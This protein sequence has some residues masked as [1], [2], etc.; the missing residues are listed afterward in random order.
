MRGDFFMLI[1]MLRDLRIAVLSTLAV[2]M[3]V[4]GI[5]PVFVWGIAQ[6]VFPENADGSLIREERTIIGSRLVGQGF[7]GK[8]Y[9]HPR[10]SHA[11]SGYDGTGSSG[12]NLGPL[13]R[14]LIE[15]IRR[16]TEVYRREN[17]LP[18]GV[19]IPPDAVTASASGLDPHISVANALLQA[20]RVAKARG[21]HEETL[22]ST[23]MANTMGRDLLILGEP[24]VNVLL[25]NLELDGRGDG[26]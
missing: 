4:C 16:R 11:G 6:I 21:L 3:L 14:N 9:F 8:E 1:S 26:G 12:S 25:L 19:P 13:S 2:A 22:R 17:C 24:R 5:Y 20:P 18:E 10:P 7:S 23:I 15:R